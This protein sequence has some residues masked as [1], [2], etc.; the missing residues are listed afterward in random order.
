MFSATFA[1]NIQSIAKKYLR[2]DFAKVEVGRVGSS[3][4]SIEQNLLKIDLP[5]NKKTKLEVLVPLLKPG[6]RTI[7]FVQKKHVATFVK[8]ALVRSNLSA[9]DIHGDRSQS[10]REAALAKFRA[11]QVDVLVATDVAARGLDVLD[12]AHVVQFDLPVSAEDFDNYVHRIGRTGR[13]GKLGRAT[14]MFVPG[15]EPKVGNGGLIPDLRRIF[16][17]NGQAL[18]VWFEQEEGGCSSTGTTTRSGAPKQA[19]AKNGSGGAKRQAAPEK[20]VPPKQTNV[21]FAPESRTAADHQSRSQ[22]GSAKKGKGKKGGAKPVANATPAG[23]AGK[24]TGGAKGKG[25]KGEERIKGGNAA[26]T[27][28]S[29]KD[30]GAGGKKGKRSGGKGKGK[31]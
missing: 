27:A 8:K 17:E 26:E 20:A 5:G 29:D 2:Q 13:A 21:V 7:V 23:P 4:A 19:P 14:A 6:E 24:S 25:K 3:I 31:W 1:P 11:G 18:P 10:Q 9:E 22:N 28:S 12:V 16:E 15:H 30:T